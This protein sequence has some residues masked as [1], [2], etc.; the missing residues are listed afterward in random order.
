MRIF[1]LLSVITSL[2]F[3]SP[4]I[5]F[6]EKMLYDGRVELLIPEQFN[7]LDDEIINRK[8]PI[9]Q[10]PDMV[11]ANDSGTINIAFKHHAYPMTQKKLRRFHKSYV[12][13]FITMNT[14]STFIGDSIYTVN[15]EQIGALEVLTPAIDTDI[16]NFIFYT[17]IEGELLICTFNCMI[18]EMPTW[19]DATQTILKSLE[20]IEIKNAD[21]L[22][23]TKGKN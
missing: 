13:S 11:Y 1:L 16:Y 5:S 19:Q 23:E 2:A 6:V 15:G 20:K 3:A 22:E 21:F 8:Y 12:E 10:I 17:D 9:D 14:A 4:T 18:E 7:V